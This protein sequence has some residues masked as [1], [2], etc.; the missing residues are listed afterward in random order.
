ML[1]RVL[2][3]FGLT[4]NAAD[5]VSFG[6]GLINRTW[7][8]S[9][10]HDA[11][12]LQQINDAIFKCPEDIAHNINVTA[13]YLHQKFP[14]YLFVQP[15]KTTSGNDLFFDKEHGYFRLTPFVEKSH[16]IDVA[17]KPE[18]AFEAASQ[19]GIFTKLLAAFDPSALKETLPH[20]HDLSLRYKQ[21]EEAVANGNALRRQQ[22]VDL[23]DALF[24]SRYIVDVFESIK[25]NSQFR[26]RATHHDTK[27]SNVLFDD[28]NKGL[29]VID[30]DTLMPGYFISDAGDML[31][32]YLSPV[33]EEEA[34][35]SKIEIREEYFSAIMQGYLG[36]LTTELSDEEKSHFVYAGK[37]MIYMQA[38]RFLTDY[39]NDDVYYGSTYEGHNF[40]RAR[41][42]LTLLQQ[43]SH[44]E[45]RLQEMVT[46]FC[47]KS[48]ATN[49]SG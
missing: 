16:T 15:I 35:L 44:K 3:A 24:D 17:R 22:S 25:T 43:L 31:R 38:L 23:I 37:F 32:T 46:L 33:S 20:F 19:F 6:S 36:A 39:L 49:V 41:N 4:A 14:H 47:K 48:I 42:Q 13:S 21:F 18:E 30:L 29:C 34:D 11:F 5:A 8:L 1:Q 9:D 10:G 40:V 7:K 27:I 2:H 12:I 28:N 45:N 26:L